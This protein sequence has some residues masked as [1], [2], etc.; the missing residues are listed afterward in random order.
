[1]LKNKINGAVC[2]EKH[3][4]CIYTEAFRKFNNLT[5]IVMFKKTL[6]SISMLFLVFAQYDS[7]AQYAPS[8][9]YNDTE[10]SQLPVSYTGHG[11]GMVNT[12]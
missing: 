9:E 2:S 12:G 8:A 7:F 3:L 5:D 10:E 1:M 6:L 11:Q 4:L